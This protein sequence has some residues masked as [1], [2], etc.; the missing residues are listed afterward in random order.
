MSA[1]VLDE[2]YYSLIIRGSQ[3]F[4]G[5]RWIGAEQLIPLKARAWID[6]SA[7]KQDGEA[8][9]TRDIRKQGNDVLRLSQLLTAESRIELSP[10]IGQDMNAFLAGMSRDNTYDPKQLQI[11]ATAREILEQISAAFGLG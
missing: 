2:D 9:D 6:L 7:R 8:I 10:K 11:K 5:L 1:I 3:V 4:D